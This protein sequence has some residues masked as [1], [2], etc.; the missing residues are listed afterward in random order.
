M[1]FVKACRICLN[2]D[3]KLHNL[4][5]F[6]LESYYDSVIGSNLL[7]TTNLPSYA[8][9]ECAHL[10]RKFYHFKQRSL[11]SQAALTGIVDK[12]G[13]LS[14][15][16][17]KQIKRQSL[18]QLSSTNIIYIENLNS[19]SDVEIKI[20]RNQQ[21]GFEELDDIIKEENDDYLSVAPLSSDDDEPLSH[22]KEK[23]EQ[24][25]IEIEKFDMKED[26]DGIDFNESNEDQSQ[27]LPD[28]SEI[29]VK[30]KKGRPRKTPATSK[31]K[32]ITKSKASI[33]NE[34]NDDLR[35]FITVISLTEAEQIEE[36][37]K[38]KTTSNYLN[39]PYQ[40]EL[41]FK[42]FIHP[43][44]WNHHV[45]KHSP[46]AGDIECHIC[47]F[48]FKTKRAFQKHLSSHEKKYACNSCPYVSTNMTQ[49]KQHQG[50]HNGV[51]FKC[52][53]CGEIFT[54]WTSY[55]SHMRIKHP[56]EF[57][58][59]ICG[60]SFISK[61]GL[62]MHKT[63]MHKDVLEKSTE[64]KEEEEPYCAECD[65]K[66]ISTKAYKRHMVMSVKHTNNMDSVKGC[67]NCGE[68]FKTSEELR[69]HHRKEHTRTR[70]KNY[71]KKQSNSW[72]AKCE[73]CSEEIANARAYWTHFRRAHPDKN[74]PVQKDYVCDVCGKSFRGNAFLVYHKRTHTEERAYKCS[75]C[76][77]AFYNRTNLHVHEKTHSDHRPYP[78]SLCFK[79]FKGKGALNRHFRS[80]TGQK[81]YECEVC[82]KSFTQS[83][84]RK[85]HVRTVHLKQPSPY[86]SRAR[87]ERR[88]KPAKDEPAFIY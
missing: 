48:R 42:G 2:M 26:V 81:P 7:Y 70:P 4:R 34:S 49:A 28:I 20:E 82:G 16:E 13:K 38:R 73:H 1:E 27:S 11:E 8:C 33:K 30:K 64:V 24:H 58:C 22:H 35:Q 23:K 65:V 62:T 60:Y 19:I 44:T 12:F 36:V 43:D 76:G 67:R 37:Q 14:P 72:P 75:Q 39:S 69:L 78:C 32:K 6:P 29:I 85:L 84:S 61:L 54:V 31:C 63:M 56:S 41:C 45:S 74:Y 18:L 25:V 53:H 9:Y 86:L 59:G 77:K 79:A 55:M 68:T 80:H 10:L 15:P 87:L 17:I 47:K 88:A 83:N 57:I 71:G 5:A 52:K 51:T 66:F 40:C 50:W 3:V 46:A 21:D